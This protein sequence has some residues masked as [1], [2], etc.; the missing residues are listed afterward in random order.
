MTHFI[1]C[2]QEDL[3]HSISCVSKKFWHILLSNSLHQMGQDFLDLYHPNHTVC[4]RSSDPFCIVTVTRLVFYVFY[5]VTYGASIHHL[6]WSL[7]IDHLYLYQAVT[8]IESNIETV[9]LSLWSLLRTLTPSF[10]FILTA[11]RERKLRIT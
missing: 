3:T 4:P 7:I 10:F 11:V 5:L 2:V 1:Y 9:F 8:A 6:A